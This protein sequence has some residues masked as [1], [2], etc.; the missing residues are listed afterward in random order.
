M[1]QF[2]RKAKTL[3]VNGCGEDREVAVPET[4]KMVGPGLLHT[5]WRG[6]TDLEA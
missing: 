6:Y 3:L 1:V 2:S 4:P 5:A